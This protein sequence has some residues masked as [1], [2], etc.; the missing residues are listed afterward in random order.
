MF[1]SNQH[2][3][4]YL[5]PRGTKP[6]GVAV[7]DSFPTFN[8]TNL[9]DSICIDLFSQVDSQEFPDT[10]TVATI[11]SAANENYE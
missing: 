5:L 3:I 2:Q 6:S 11:T 1:Q 7:L 10:S 4:Q 9:T 8:L